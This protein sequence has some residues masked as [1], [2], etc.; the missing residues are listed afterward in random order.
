MGHNQL[1]EDTEVQF[2]V[3]EKINRTLMNAVNLKNL[4]ENLKEGLNKQLNQK[5]MDSHRLTSKA[6]NLSH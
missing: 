4:R 1:E 5:I 3:F 2:L 6:A